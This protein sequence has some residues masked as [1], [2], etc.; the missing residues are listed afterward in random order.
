[1]ATSLA[2]LERAASGTGAAAGRRSGLGDDGPVITITP[3]G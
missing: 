1:M 2:D 3:R